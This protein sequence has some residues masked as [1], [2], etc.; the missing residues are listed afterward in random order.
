M[1]NSAGLLLPDIVILADLS[2][3]SPAASHTSAATLLSSRRA[4]R[5]PPVASSF[6]L[7]AWLPNAFP[8]FRDVVSNIAKVLG[9]VENVMFGEIRAAATVPRCKWQVLCLC[10]ID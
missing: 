3:A 5:Q 2:C 1:D 7:R 9:E 10:I 4:S 8:C 6:C